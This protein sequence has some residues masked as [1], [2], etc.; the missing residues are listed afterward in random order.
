MRKRELPAALIALASALVLIVLIYVGSRGLK[1]FDSALIGY[2]VATI[3]A[4][5]AIVYR[6][7]LWIIR[8]PRL[9]LLQGR[10]AEL[11]FVAELPALY[12]ADPTLVVDRHLCADLYPQTQLCPLG[13][14]HLDFLGRDALAGDN[15]AADLRLDS[16]Q[17]DP[18]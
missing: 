15:L 7:T 16:L 3:F 10:M 6:Y 13:G 2:A 18:A 17:S 12:T 9:A 1:D 4:T 14:T 8:P 5:A 11:P